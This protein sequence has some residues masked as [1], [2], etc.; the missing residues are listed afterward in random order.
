MT[1]RGGGGW[2]GGVKFRNF[3]SIGENGGI[4]IFLSEVI[5]FICRLVGYNLGVQVNSRI[6][7]D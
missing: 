5:E 1:F 2:R 7:F 3:H 6:E 4:S